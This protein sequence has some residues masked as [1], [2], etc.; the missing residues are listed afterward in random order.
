[1]SVLSIYIE[2]SKSNNCFWGESTQRLSYIPKDLNLEV[3]KYI[4]LRNLE[5][6]SLVSREWRHLVLK[7]GRFNLEELSLIRKETFRIH[8]KDIKLAPRKD[9]SIGL[10]GLL[11]TYSYSFTD[12]GLRSILKTLLYLLK[13]GSEKHRGVVFEKVLSLENITPDRKRLALGFF[14]END[15]TIGSDNPN[16][17]WYKFFAALRA[18]YKEDKDIAFAAIKNDP[19]ATFRSIPKSLMEDKE[20]VLKATE[21]FEKDITRYS[22]W[23][24]DIGH[25]FSP[26]LMGDKAFVLE[27]YKINKKALLFASK[28]LLKKDPELRKKH[29][30]LCSLCPERCF[31][32]AWNF[33]FYMM[34]ALNHLEPHYSNLIIHP[35]AIVIRDI[36]DQY[37]VFEYPIESLICFIENIP[38]ASNE[39]DFRKKIKSAHKMTNDNGI[40]AT[41]QNLLFS[42]IFLEKLKEP[43]KEIL[44]DKENFK[45]SS[46]EDFRV[47]VLEKF[48]LEKFNLPWFSGIEGLAFLNSQMRKKNNL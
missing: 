20:I 6:P 15:F 28:D 22:E 21:L 47:M 46:L 40:K 39:E 8:G 17:R 7:D 1:M 18:D 44:S 19:Y 29:L 13:I 48:M 42:S 3:F 26:R 43:I 5:S 9:G 11:N 41:Y 27:A 24:Y 31:G 2:N 34:Q 14:S 16:F 45:I 30:E 4:P 33:G 36:L 10:F 12:A 37:D 32:S 23:D 25:R 35:L 38:F